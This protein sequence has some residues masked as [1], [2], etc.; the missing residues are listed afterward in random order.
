VSFLKQHND[1]QYV[2]YYELAKDEWH[3]VMWHGSH[4]TATTITGQQRSSW[5]ERL[6]EAMD[7]LL[8]RGEAYITSPRYPQPPWTDEERRLGAYKTGIWSDEATRFLSGI[9]EPKP[10]LMIVK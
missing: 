3:L 5:G 9:P 6:T 10:N 1:C 2:E 7:M 8:G 4:W